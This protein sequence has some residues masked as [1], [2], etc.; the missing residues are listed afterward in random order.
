[1]TI[2][3]NFSSVVLYPHLYEHPSVDMS[4]SLTPFL[5]GFRVHESETGFFNFFYVGV[6]VLPV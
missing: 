4:Y 5:Y 6:L 3:N 1:M 2:E